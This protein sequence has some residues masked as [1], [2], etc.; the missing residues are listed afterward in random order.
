MLSVVLMAVG[1]IVGLVDT[2]PQA[3]P[4]EYARLKAVTPRDAESQVKLALWCEAHGLESERVRHLAIAVLS[5]P[6]NALARGL[7]GLVEVQ[8]KWKRPDDVAKSIKNDTA[9]ADLIAEY[10]G[11]RVKTPLAVLPQFKLALWCEEKGL[12]DEARA[13][14]ATVVRLDPNHADAWKKLGYKKVNNR[15][16][17]DAQA[18]AMKSEKDSQDKADKH[19]RPRLEKLR[20]SF[21]G[22]GNHEQAEQELREITDPRAVPAIWSVFVTKNTKHHP[23]AVQLL[24]QIDAIEASRALATLSIFAPSDDV[25]RRATETLRRRDPREYADILIGLMREKIKYEVKHVG[26]PGSPGELYIAG[27]KQNVKRVYAPPAAPNVAVLPGDTMQLDANGLP[28]L[29]HH[30]YFDTLVGN[31]TPVNWNN[32]DSNSASSLIDPKALSQ[33]ADQIRAKLPVGLN[34][35]NGQLMQISGMLDPRWQAL[36]ATPPIAINATPGLRASTSQYEI[37][38]DFQVGVPVGQM[39]AEAQRVAMS[40]EQQLSADVRTLDN[41]NTVIGEWNDRITAVLVTA[42]GANIKPDADAWKTWFV[43]QLGFRYN[44]STPD[45][46]PTVYDD[47]PL[48]DQARA[49]PLQFDQQSTAFQIFRHSCFGKGTLVQTDSGPRAIET[50]QAGDQVL[51]QN[52]KTGKL[53]Y[54]PIVMIHHNP[55]ST[56]CQVKLGDKS[57]VTSLTHRFWKAG[58]GWVMARDLQ[59]GDPIRTLGGVARITAIENDKVQPVFNLDIAENADFF[60][61]DLAVL[62]HDNTLPD[63]KQPAF[64]APVAVATKP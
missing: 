2:P 32:R 63:L 10:N 26:G 62:V 24:G 35:N 34:V 4:A 25:R 11:K 3:D 21:A 59:V 64:D 40:A 50:L 9:H 56:T 57:V 55:P 13:H 1:S 5:D 30:R 17:T 15:W 58:H 44:M 14:L 37:V 28:V 60:V 31:P 36:L 18:T 29:V 38:N 41:Q 39:A 48:V 43:D 33:Q 22:K 51:S 27:K 54:Q 42:T 16:I 12:K 6:S 45:E 61:G 47:V 20:D 49:I 8:G 53:G 46:V 52:T 7:M 19:W 23:R